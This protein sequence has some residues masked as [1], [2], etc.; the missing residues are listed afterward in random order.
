MIPVREAYQYY[1]ELA[2][3][4]AHM[5]TT[6]RFSTFVPKPSSSNPENSTLT[7]ATPTPTCN[8]SRSDTNSDVNG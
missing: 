1:S 4:E 8:S 5:Q 3:R 7:T 6:P 2:E